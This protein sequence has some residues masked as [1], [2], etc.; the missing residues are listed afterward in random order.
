MSPPVS[1]EELIPEVYAELRRL[2]RSYLRRMPSGAILQPTALVH[3]TFLWFSSSK[4][5]PWVSQSHFLGVAALAMRQVLGQ[6]FRRSNALKRGGKAFKIELSGNSELASPAVADYAD[7]DRAL[8]RLEAE[9][10]E[11]SR[12]V[13]LRSFGGLSVEECAGFLSLSPATVNRR[14]R[15]ARAWLFRELSAPGT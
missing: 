2:A 9:A 12:I 5:P 11:L 10:P 4:Q 13:E 1:T 8:N 7:L 15:L 6:H 14:W 3:E